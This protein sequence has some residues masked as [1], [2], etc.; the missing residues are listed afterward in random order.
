MSAAPIPVNEEARLAA[1]AELQILDTAPEPEFDNLVDL[2]ART[3]E[4]PI[5]LISLVDRDRQWF[6]ARVGIDAR[7]TPREFAFCAHAILEDGPFVVPD[8]TVDP[9]FADNPLVVGAPNIR[10]YAGMTL[11]SETGYRLGTLCVIDDRPRQAS[12]ELRG[13]LT[14]LARTTSSLIELR[15]RRL[16][17]RAFAAEQA[18]TASDLQRTTTLLRRIAGAQREFLVGAPPRIIFGELLDALVAAS[19]SEYGFIAEVLH[20]GE[21]RPF[22]QTS[23]ITDVV[24]SGPHHHTMAQRTAEGMR[25]T[26]LDTLFGL[27]IRQGAAVISNAP[28]SD[29][30][31]GGLPPGHPPLHSF[32][33][34]PCF[35]G[36]EMVGMIGVANRKGG[37]SERDVDT[38]DALTGTCAALFS[39]LRVRRL[40]REAEARRRRSDARLGAIIESANEAIVCLDQASAIRTW[41]PEAT[42]IFGWTVDEAVG[43]DFVELLAPPDRRA[44]ARELLAGALEAGGNL[45]QVF[46]VE[47][48]GRDG[49]RVPLDVSLARVACGGEIELSAFMRDATARKAAERE[50]RARSD[51]LARVNVE[52]GEALRIKDEFLATVSHELRTPLQAVIGRTASLLAGHH[53]A[54]SAVQSEVLRTIGASGELLLQLINDL[55][56]LTKVEAQQLALKPGVVDV[57]GVVEASI[58]VVEALAERKS[59]RIERDI[60]AKLPSLHLDALRFEQVLINV[61]SNAVKFTSE[62]SI[63]V[64]VRLDPAG[65]RLVVEVEDTGIGIPADQ[66]ERIFD[67]FTQVDGGLRRRHAGTGLGLALTRRLVELFGGTIAVKSALGVGSTFTIS[68]PVQTLD[69]ERQDERQRADERRSRRLRVLLADD[70]EI[71]V[72]TISAFLEASGHEVLVAHDGGEAVALFEA[73]HPDVILLDLQMPNV[74]GIDA[75]RR[76]RATPGR[77]QPPIVALTAM[78]RTS[79][80]ARC[81]EAGFDAFLTKPVTPERLDAMIAAA[82]P[83]GTADETSQDSAE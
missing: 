28:A 37:Y 12:P 74:D 76:I 56:D 62:G 42:R 79:D 72:L 44:A 1:L 16:R 19:E 20:D 51:E 57:A 36:G 25:F 77:H 30:R 78:G 27:V 55:L 13:S 58:A 48:V 70:N 21:G 71:N 26:N 40:G 4:T 39:H 11:T 38:L 17:D 3:S 60:E 22:L 29:P 64:R 10:F 50:L 32:L 35:A 7:E 81:L 82:V 9:R 15:H 75:A 61:L 5:A 63:R 2:A 34:V 6:K 45:G 69:A 59:L 43:R 31:R 52:L 24:W 73:Q 41:N 18:R 53:G 67:P 23:A 14:A 65:P 83:R 8:A 54:L 66:L 68:L 49:Q 33:G 46:E 47:G 80:R